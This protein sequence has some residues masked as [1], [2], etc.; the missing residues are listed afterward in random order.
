MALTTTDSGGDA[1]QGVR[2]ALG[3]AS[4]AARFASLLYGDK[5]PD[6]LGAVSSEWLADNVEAAFAFIREKPRAGH[7]VGIRRAPANGDGAA[8]SVVEILNDDM[9]FLVDSAMG[10]LQARGL[11]VGQL[12]HPIFKARRDPAGRLQAILGPGDQ[13]WND[14]QQESYIAI[15]VATGLSETI[16]GDLAGTLSAIL[17]EV[18]TAVEDWQPMRRLVQE[19]ARRLEQSALRTA[20]ADIGE[21]V[22]FLHWL[23]NNNFTFLGAREHRLAHSAGAD[24]LL[25]VEASGLGMLRNPTVNALSSQAARAVAPLVISKSSLQSRVHRRVTMDCVAVKTWGADGSV[26]GEV[27]IVGLFTSQ[28]YTTSPRAIPLLRHKVETVLGLSGYPAASHDGKAL[29]NVLET[30]PRDELFEIDADELRRWS[31][32]ILDLEIR[33]RVR[34]FARGDRFHRFVTALVYVPRDRYTSAVRERIAAVLAQ[35]YGAR[36]AAFYPYFTESPLVRV[37][38]ILSRTE[39]VTPQVDTLELERRIA[40]LI[41]TWDDRLMEAI[42][43]QG[44]AAEA[45][46]ARYAA[47]FPA[48]Y[49]AAFPAERALHDIQRIE[50][51]GPDMTVAIEFYRETSAPAARVSAAV[52]RFGGPISLS[53]RVPLLENLGFRAIDERTY[54]LRPR[55]PDGPRTVTLHDMLLETSDGTTI[56]LAMHGPRLEAAFHAVFGG[57][58][59]ND[60]FNRLVVSA[61]ADWRSV[62]ALRGL[63]AYLR[64]LG[65]PFGPRYI[66]DTLHRHAGVTRD[67]LELFHLRFDPDRALDAGARRAAEAQIRGR[68]EGALAA[69]PSLDEDRILRL[70]LNLIGAIV[71]T[72][73]Y[74]TA[75]SGRGAHSPANK[76]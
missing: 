40:G 20:R 21:A 59:D 14:G 9:P 34:V 5:V 56:D 3:E 61:G 19:A 13:S 46:L 27:H 68:I 67:L 29:L 54:F 72:N 37:Q 24:K 64:Q 15:Y 63:A 32:G 44:S 10:E 45:L 75:Q 36:L 52:Y 62:A 25:A 57:A 18:R 8:L 30:F 26:S 38:F 55:F 42:A 23:A 17:G 47:A 39:G 69:V 33:P 48:D 22:A 70:V 6:G 43:A 58:A 49:A 50:R 51:L 53:Q 12:L 16:A 11:A 7:K 65:A 28:A 76:G 31:E 73:F 71:R 35:A 66:A 41:R 1:L 2:R 74:Q 60:T 4:L